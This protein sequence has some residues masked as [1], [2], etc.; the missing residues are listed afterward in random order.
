MIVLG[1]SPLD[2]DSHASLVVD[3]RAL[4][5]AGTAA[6]SYVFVYHLYRADGVFYALAL[7]CLARPALELTDHARRYQWGDPPARN[8]QK[9]LSAAP[10]G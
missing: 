9:S 4:F 5:A 10:A 3:G 8:A 2:K 7:A 6:L 1:L